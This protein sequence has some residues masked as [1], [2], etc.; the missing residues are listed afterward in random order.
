MGSSCRA[1]C[2]VRPRHF[3]WT[4]SAEDGT[5]FRRQVDVG[6]RR[7]E[8]ALI[9][10]DVMTVESMIEPMD[11]DSIYVLMDCVGMLDFS[12]QSLVIESVLS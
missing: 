8:R 1:S 4:H 7:G 9:F 12:L 2:A 6:V 11:L 5:R 10:E 3:E